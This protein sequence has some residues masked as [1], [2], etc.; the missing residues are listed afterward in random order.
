MGI[1]STSTLLSGRGPR[2][3]S[4]ALGHHWCRAFGFWG[5]LELAFK[6]FGL[7]GTV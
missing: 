6:V 1:A 2:I 3:T 7:W 5:V 4:V